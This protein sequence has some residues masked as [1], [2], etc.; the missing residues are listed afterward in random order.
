MRNVGG[1]EAKFL[2]SGWKSREPVAFDDGPFGVLS[3]YETASAFRPLSPATL[4]RTLKM[5]LWG[6]YN[7]EKNRHP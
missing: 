2:D 7:R 4:K 5:M 1:V 6:E 3:A